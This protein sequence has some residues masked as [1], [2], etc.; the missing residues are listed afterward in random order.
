VRAYRRQ[1]PDADGV[2][3]ARQP[4]QEGRHVLLLKLAGHLSSGCVVRATDVLG[5]KEGRSR[6]W[7]GVPNSLWCAGDAPWASKRSTICLW[8]FL[9]ATDRTV[10]FP[11]GS[12]QT[13]NGPFFGAQMGR[14]GR[15]REAVYRSA[16]RCRRARW[17][18]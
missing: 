1:R 11:F 16:G 3:I 18:R 13:A 4:A 5:G 17:S 8:P 2:L 14:G 10:P 15:R 7:G 12:G 6:T 9:D